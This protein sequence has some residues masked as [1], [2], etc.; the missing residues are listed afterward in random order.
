M[1]RIPLLRALIDDRYAGSQK[2]FADAIKRAPAQVNQWLSG[3]RKIGDA[4]ARHIEKV[5]GI[6]GYFDGVRADPGE[7]TA[8]EAALIAQFRR[9]TDHER[10]VFASDIAHRVS[11]SIALNGK[12]TPDARVAECLPAA[13]Q[14]KKAE[15]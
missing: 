5:F 12:P 10:A 7:L 14:K 1:D 13:P 8:Q 11:V 4:G 15:Q 3:H 9:L 2:A 6:P